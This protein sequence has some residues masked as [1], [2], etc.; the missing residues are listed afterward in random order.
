M[1]KNVIVLIGLILLV[2]FTARANAGMKS[3]IGELVNE[4]DQVTLYTNDGRVR[5][6]TTGDVQDCF[7]GE[8]NV[9]PSIKVDGAYELVETVFCRGKG[10]GFDFGSMKGAAL[11][12]E[13]IVEDTEE[14]TVLLEDKLNRCPNVYAPVCGM[15]HN[16]AITFQ[17][18]CELK[19]ANATKLFLGECQGRMSRDERSHQ[20]F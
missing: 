14:E 17:N 19:R 1:M 11:I 20:E 13:E 7:H 18:M 3:V 12:S 9:R 10:K 2:A 16:E 4:G 15:K 5:I 8:Y 6:E